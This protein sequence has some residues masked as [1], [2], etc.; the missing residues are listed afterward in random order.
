M[1]FLWVTYWYYWLKT[2]ISNSLETTGW[3]DMG[4]W[5][6]RMC[7]SPFLKSGKTLAILG[8]FGKIPVQRDWLMTWISGNTT[9]SSILFQNEPIYHHGQSCF[10]CKIF[11]IFSLSVTL[12]HS[13][14]KQDITLCFRKDEIV[15]EPLYLMLCESY[16]PT[17]A[18]KLFK[19]LEVSVLSS[20]F[21]PFNA[22]KAGKSFFLAFIY[23]LLNGKPRV[24][25][26][27]LILIKLAG[28]ISYLCLPDECFQHFIIWF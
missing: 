19:V 15:L 24:P 17:L 27:W 20:K 8:R 25:D 4:R 13:K 11:T 7:W 9:V 18:K 21:L 2:T 26:I 28:I 14:S 22:K 10:L 23:Y 12:T 5:L 16:V 6:S 1:R 3:R